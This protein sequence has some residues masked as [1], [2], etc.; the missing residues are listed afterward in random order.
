[1]GIGAILVIIGIVLAVT[2]RLILGLIL[3]ILGLA[4][5]GFRRGS[6]Y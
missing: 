1:M 2:D 6:W 4:F 3:I 5:G